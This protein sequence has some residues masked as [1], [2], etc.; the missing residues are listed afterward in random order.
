VEIILETVNPDLEQEIKRSGGYSLDVQ[1]R[2]VQPLEA[3]FKDDRI[4]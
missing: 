2:M 3:G 4:S 1:V